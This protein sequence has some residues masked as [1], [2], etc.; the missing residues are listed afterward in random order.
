MSNEN[1]HQAN[2]TDPAQ[3]LNDVEDFIRRFVAFPSD[4]ALVAAAL[5]A[6]HCHVLDAFDTTPRL[7]FLSP[8][9]GS[10]KTRAIEILNLLVPWPILAAN[11]SFAALS[12]AVAQTNSRPTILFDEIDTV[13]GRNAKPNEDLRALINAGYR[14][15]GTSLRCVG[16]NFEPTQFPAYSALAVAGLGYLPETIADRA[17]VVKMRRR[18]PNESIDSFRVRDHTPLGHALRDAL[19]EAFPPHERALSERRPELPDGVSDRSADIWE[20]L[21]AIAEVAG[22]DWP[23]RARDACVHFVRAAKPRVSLGMQLLSDIRTVFSAAN[24][25]SSSDL[26]QKL[27]NMEDAPWADLKG[28]GLDQ[29][30]LASMLKPYEVKPG[31]IREREDVYRGYLRADFHDAWQRYLPHTSEN[32]LHPLQPLQPSNDAGFS[33][34][35]KNPVTATPVT[36]DTKEARKQADVTDVADVTAN[37]GAGGEEQSNATLFST[38]DP[39]LDVPMPDDPI[40][41][42]PMPDDPSRA[43]WWSI[44]RGASRSGRS[45]AKLSGPGKPLTQT[46]WRWCH[47]YQKEQLG[48]AA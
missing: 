25:M 30:G 44:Y 6:A 27:C 47:H 38:R 13:F 9:P 20:P 14:K 17:I 11:A 31:T 1:H 12:R 21:L 35:D 40:L 8:E 34:T 39:M 22:S 33:V 46:Q 5:W 37:K 10:G 48:E 2:A 16:P 28:K 36:S 4:H 29:R 7:A 43:Q 18:G 41:G 23:R 3:A 26:V 19:S 15:S 42:L 32:P 24:R 45:R